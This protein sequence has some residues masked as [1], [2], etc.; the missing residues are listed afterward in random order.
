MRDRARGR[1]AR[2]AGA[3]RAR[4][5]REF[6]GLEPSETPGRL[7]VAEAA[8]VLGVA[9]PEVARHAGALQSRARSGGEGDGTVS[10]RAT[11]AAGHAPPAWLHRARGRAPEE[12]LPR[13]MTSRTHVSRSAAAAM[14]GVPQPQFR[15]LVSAGLLPLHGPNR[16]PVD[17][18]VRLRAAHPPLLHDLQLQL[19]DT[20]FE[21][22]ARARA[23]APAPVHRI[24]VRLPVRRH[25]PETVVFHL[26]PTNSGKTH[27]ALAFLAAEGAGTFAAPLRML[28]QEAYERLCGLAGAENVGLVT[29]EERV[30]EN[31]P[32]IACTAEMAPMRGQV[33]VLDECHWA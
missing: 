5:W 30:N 2:E 11:L 28:A 16:V 6:L 3:R 10:L 32:I 26:G 17:A 9:E 8:A 24:E 1:G 25:E 27:D 15:R 31:A 20:A 29:G 7:S 22:M 19:P 18:L 12:D 23:S 33:L 4:A 14:L 21:A 13:R